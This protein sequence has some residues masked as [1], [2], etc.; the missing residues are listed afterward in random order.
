MNIVTLSSLTARKRQLNQLCTAA[1]EQQ[2]EQNKAENTQLRKRRRYLAKQLLKR[3]SLG[4]HHSNRH[5]LHAVTMVFALWGFNDLLMPNQAEAAPSFS[6]E[7]PFAGVDAG[8]WV[9]PVFADIDG[10]GDLDVFMGHGDYGIKY[11][12]NTEIDTV[13]QG[14]GFVSDGAANPLA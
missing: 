8:Q 10:D 12:R 3:V 5:W 6:T 11:F 2:V 13:A 4:Q 7:N 14:T 1:V 9:S